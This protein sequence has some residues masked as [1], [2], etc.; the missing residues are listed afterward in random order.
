M[1]FNVFVHSPP[2]PSEEKG[3]EE[4]STFTVRL[5]YRLEFTKRTDNRV[6]Y[7]CA[8]VSASLERTWYNV[9]IEECK[10]WSKQK[11][12]ANWS[13]FEI[14]AGYYG[15]FRDFLKK[16]RD[17]VPSDIATFTVNRDVLKIAVKQGYQMKFGDFLKNIFTISELNQKSPSHTYSMEEM[18][19]EWDKI[20][21]F[22]ECP[23]FLSASVV[24]GSE[25]CVL[26]AI[27]ILVSPK[28][29]GQMHWE[30]KNL[31]FKD[32][33]TPETNSL[34]VEIR[35]QYGKKLCFF[36]RKVALHILIRKKVE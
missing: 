29:F 23:G 33:I 24:N 1:E 36:R 3:K 30:F 19:N 12:K 2:L 10:I 22:F 14:P 11:N 16:I 17:V 35:N 28:K 9:G 20:Q 6:G 26:G 32:L 4:S 27:P 7:E 34:A 5:P 31:I 8:L 15:E 18:E 21:V 25:R 13:E